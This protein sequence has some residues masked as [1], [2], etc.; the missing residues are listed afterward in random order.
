MHR[1][2]GTEIAD[3]S[4]SGPDRPDERQQQAEPSAQKGRANSI[5]AAPGSDR[6]TGDEEQEAGRAEDQVE[7][8]HRRPVTLRLMRPPDEKECEPED[9][10]EENRDLN[11]CGRPGSNSAIDRRSGGTWPAQV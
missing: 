6:Q 3:L 2:V 11:H 1:V 5:G 4:E 9:E 8:D 10:E 7:T